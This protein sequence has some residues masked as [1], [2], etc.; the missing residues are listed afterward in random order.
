MPE[1]KKQL[2]ELIQEQRKTMKTW[3]LQEIN[4]INLQIFALR[5]KIKMQMA[6]L[7]EQE[8][9]ARQNARAEAFAMQH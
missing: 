9:E 2:R 3:D 8:Q 4:K 5:E 6:E 1:T 7:R